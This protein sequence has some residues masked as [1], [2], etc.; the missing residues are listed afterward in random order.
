MQTCDDCSNCTIYARNESVPYVV[1]EGDMARM[2][3]GNRRSMIL[4]VIQF[5]VILVLIGLLYWQS[6]Q[7]EK[8]TETTVQDVWQEA[9]SGGY[10]RFVGGD[11][12]GDTTESADDA[13]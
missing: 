6:V 11:N 7:Y 10:N 13:H 12:Y 5:I 1:H 9:E 2:E 3:R 8:V 4:N